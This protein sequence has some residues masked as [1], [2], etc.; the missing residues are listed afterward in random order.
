MIN[1]P[2]GVVKLVIS[3]GLDSLE[4]RNSV[5]DQVIDLSELRQNRVRK[6]PQHIFPG[7]VAPIIEIDLQILRLSLNINDTNLRP[8]R[9]EHLRRAPSDALGAA[10]D[11]YYFILKLT[12]CPGLLIPQ[13]GPASAAALAAS[14]SGFTSTSAYSGCLENH[15]IE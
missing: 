11:H 9:A 12:H 1:D 8:L 7:N 5:I 4:Q 14:S 2:Q 10:C 13:A 3:T 6:V 15:L